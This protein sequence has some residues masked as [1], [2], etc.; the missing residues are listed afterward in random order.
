M[1]NNSSSIQQTVMEIQPA[2]LR[3]AYGFII[4]NNRNTYR[5]QGSYNS[6]TGC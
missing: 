5:N 4:K 3:L 2:P 6:R 1:E